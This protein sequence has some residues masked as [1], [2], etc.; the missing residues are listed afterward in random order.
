MNNVQILRE[1]IAVL[2]QELNQENRP[3][4]AKRLRAISVLLTA[5]PGIAGRLVALLRGV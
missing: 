3:Q 2:V 4:A 1:A 5:S